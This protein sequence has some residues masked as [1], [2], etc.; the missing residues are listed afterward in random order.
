MISRKDA[1]AAKT[2]PPANAGLLPLNC[3]KGHFFRA[4]SLKKRSVL[5]IPFRVFSSPTARP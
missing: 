3:P 4:Q 5:K 1:K 2:N